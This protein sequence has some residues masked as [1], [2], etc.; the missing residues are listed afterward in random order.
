MALTELRRGDVWLVG[1]GAGRPG[2]PG[3]HRPA[4]VVTAD[5]LLAGPVDD[6]VA[7][8]AVSSSRAGSALRPSVGPEDGV[9]RASV[10]ICRGVRAVAPSRLVQKLGT[11]RPETLAAV[12]R[13]LAVV[14]EL[15]GDR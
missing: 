13:A 1:F 5:S 8:V 14:L 12:D 3:K 4:I 15:D 9:E 10:A 6:L 11:A 2:E 7:V